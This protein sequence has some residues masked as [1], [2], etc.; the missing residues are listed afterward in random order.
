MTTR[1]VTNG[2]EPMP[3]APQGRKGAASL[4]MV[5]GECVFPDSPRASQGALR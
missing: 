5:V 3:V 4:R 1:G 2:N